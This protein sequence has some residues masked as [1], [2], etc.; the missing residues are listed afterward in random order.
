MDFVNQFALCKWLLKAK[1]WNSRL[2]KMESQ[3]EEIESRLA[4]P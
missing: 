4:N 3:L 2:K 1:I